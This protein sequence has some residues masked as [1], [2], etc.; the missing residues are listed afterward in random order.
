L[1]IFISHAITDEDLAIKLKKFLENSDQIEEAYIARRSPDFD[2]EIADKITREI[3]NSDYLV[4]IITKTS[5][6]RPSVHQELGFAQGVNVFKIPLIEK[7]AQKGVLLEGRDVFIFQKENFETICKDVLKYI[8]KKGPRPK[9]SKEEGIYA[10]KS[11]HF[12][13]EIRNCFDDIL[14]SIIYRLRFVP[15]NN[16]DLLSSE[17]FENRMKVFEE[18]FRFVD[19]DITDLEKYFI[20]V[21]LDSFTRFSNEFINFQDDVKDAKEFPHDDLFP[22]ESDAFQKFNKRISEIVEGSFDIQKDVRKYFED[23]ETFRYYDDFSEIMKEHP[24][25]VPTP[26]RNYFRMKLT[27][28]V[29]MTNLAN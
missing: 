7:D 28:F 19:Q 8:A 2:I 4:A 21:P 6:Q 20:K 24:D 1:R 5:M 15:E 11:S 13:Y 29:Y 26:L 27:A 10:Q 14:D 3:N 18:I 12:R 9:F 25:M 17:K 22:E 16:R 23:E